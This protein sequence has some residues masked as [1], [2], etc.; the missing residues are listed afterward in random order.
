MQK[1]LLI[2]I[3]VHSIQ[4]K[5]IS[6]S[7]W[8]TP[9][10]SFFKFKGNVESFELSGYYAIYDSPKDHNDTNYHFR[11]KPNYTIVNIFD[12]KGR[13]IEYKSYWE[14]K[15]KNKYDHYAWSYD[16][17]DRVIEK[18]IYSKDGSGKLSSKNVF[19]FNTNGKLIMEGSFSSLDSCLWKYTYEYHTN[20]NL[21]KQTNW[22]GLN[23]EKII[24]YN[25]Q[26]KPIRS[27]NFLDGKE[28]EI[29]QYKRPSEEV[30]ICEC[31][32]M[33]G[34]FISRKEEKV[35]SSG[36]LIEK[37]WNYKNDYIN[38]E[39]YEYNEDGKQISMIEKDKSGK[40]IKDEKHFYDS[41]GRKIETI[42]KYS[43]SN[44]THYK[45]EYDDNDNISVTH[46][47]TNKK[48]E[49]FFYIYDDK[50]NWIEYEEW[51]QYVGYPRQIIMKKIRVIKYR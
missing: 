9:S 6:Q 47:I 28:N 45:Y 12:E 46:N 21:S 17:L 40:L 7:V 48:V 34:V 41:K 19:Q 20:S 11:T 37:K 13:G 29:C 3:L 50:G 39:I 14:S 42:C 33:K 36:K 44:N 51:E 15:I 30:E 10:W 8:D 25:E 26:G 4:M 23:I 24:D 49:Y 16:S 31:K 35:N 38:H 2:F 5:F 1:L 22:K 43:K 18:R 32:D 27:I